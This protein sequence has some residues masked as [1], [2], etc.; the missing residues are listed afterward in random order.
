MWYY[1]PGDP[2]FTMNNRISRTALLYDHNW[3]YSLKHVAFL[4][5]SSTALRFRWEVGEKK[6]E[7][8]PEISLYPI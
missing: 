3:P 4:G 1:A 2:D 8:I 6:P 5:P 7:G